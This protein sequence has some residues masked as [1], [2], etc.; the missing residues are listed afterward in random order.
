MYVRNG[1]M[2]L[3]W[4]WRMQNEG[5]VYADVLFLVN[6]SM[7]FLCFYVLSVLRS[8]RLRFLRTGI[9]S[10]IGGAY[11]V[12][13]VVLDLPLPLYIVTALAVPVIMC[14]VEQGKGE[15]G[16]GDLLRTAFGFFGV[17]LALGGVMTGIYSLLNGTKLIRDLSG[18][19]ADG[20][21]DGLS[22]WIFALLA[23]SGGAATL[24][25]GRNWRLRSV[26]KQGIMKLTY[27]GMTVSVRGMTDTGNLL[28]DPLSG[29]AV[30]ICEL[31]A[32]RDLFPPELCRLWSGGG[33][34]GVNELSEETAAALRFIPAESALGKGAVITAIRPDSAVFETE[35]G[36]R[37][38]DILVAP[39][40][41]KLS[42][43]GSRALFPPGLI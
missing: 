22:V 16:A 26:S 33:I 1:G 42:A 24:I 27:R 7:D 3:S 12:A 15:G 8:R 37:A 35:N 25:G 31:D 2:R 17:S 21:E 14:A 6:F 4:L 19:G 18:G 28:T 11:S 5:S 36:D 41:K 10:A 20:A 30:V 29:R 9:A 43:G 23:A 13:A 34:G 40:A 38:A 39:V 32:V